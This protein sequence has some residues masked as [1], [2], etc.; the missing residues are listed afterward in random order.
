MSGINIQSARVPEWAGFFTKDEYNRFMKCVSEYFSSGGVSYLSDEGAI[1]NP[2]PREL[3][4]EKMG[5]LNLA[6][7]CRLRPAEEWGSVIHDHFE[8]IRRAASFEK[9]FSKR[10]H[11]FNAVQDLIGVR[12]YPQEYVSVIENGLAMGKQMAE[13]LYAMLVF[14]FEECIVNIRPEQTIQWPLSSEELLELGIRN[15]KRKYSLD[16]FERDVEGIP[17]H[18]VVESHFYAPNILFELLREKVSAESKGM[19]IGL[20]NRHAAMIHRITDLKVL[21]AIHRMIPAI[22]GMNKD[23]PGAVSDKLY[24]LHNGNMVTLPYKIDEVNIHFDPPAEF[25]G[26]LRELQTDGV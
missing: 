17:I 14:D 1:V 3:S 20:P 15:T 2:G 8:G 25:I 5:L 19:L 4:A 18:F 23:G 22:H 11:D 13:D 26:L 9:D 24:W 16:L 21:E 10:A 12:L 6:Q 7:F